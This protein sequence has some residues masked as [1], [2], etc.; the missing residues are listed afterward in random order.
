MGLKTPQNAYAEISVSPRNL[1]KIYDL[2]TRSAT[3][4]VSLPETKAN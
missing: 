2:H 3:K 4:L 1:L